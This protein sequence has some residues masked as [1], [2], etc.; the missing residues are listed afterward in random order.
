MNEMSSG[1][2]EILDGVS[3]LKETT[4][5]VDESAKSIDSMVG[6]IRTAT[7]HLSDISQEQVNGIG[8]ISTGISQIQTTT[9]AL[10]RLG[11]E[12]AEAIEVIKKN[13]VQF[14]DS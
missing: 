8:E 1:G 11:T 6:A 9:Q 7:D 10:S 13:I 3:R 14:Q 2:A 4:L 5:V 12:N